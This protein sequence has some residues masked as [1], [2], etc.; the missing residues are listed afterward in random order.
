MLSQPEERAVQ[1][2]VCNIQF[3]NIKDLREHI[4]VHMDNLVLGTRVNVDENIIHRFYQINDKYGNEYNLSDS[5]SDN[6]TYPHE[7]PKCGCLFNRAYKLNQH[8]NTLHPNF[9]LALP[10]F[11]KT[12]YRSFSTE[13]LL[14]RHNKHQCDNTLKKYACSQCNIKFMWESNWEKHNKR[15]H[16]QAVSNDQKNYQCNICGKSYLIK[17]TLERHQRIHDPAEKK[18]ACP[19]CNKRFFRSDY[20]RPHMLNVHGSSKEDVDRVLWNRRQTNL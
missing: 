19:M 2:K 14:N 1:C 12:C 6:E 16:P 18:F 9:M 15:Y 10:H 5:E 8:I 13:A 7:C 20:L 17:R 4:P 11:C 3:A